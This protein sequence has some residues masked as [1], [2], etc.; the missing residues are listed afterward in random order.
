MGL[1][2]HDGQEEFSRNLDAVVVRN[3]H[4][5]EVPVNGSLG[6]FLPG[7]GQEEPSPRRVLG[8]GLEELVPNE[9]VR[10]HYEANGLAPCGLIVV[11]NLPAEPMR[12]VRPMV[13][14]SFSTTRRSSPTW[15][16][17]GGPQALRRQS[18]P[19]MRPRLTPENGSIGVGADA[20]S[21]GGTG[22]TRLA[23][24]GPTP[25][26]TLTES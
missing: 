25:P 17:M 6:R 24:R 7:V 19:L 20:A 3:P 9:E 12:F 21:H 11:L 13:T 2:W 10:E 22:G 1:A 14:A 4:E 15:S 8:G 16:P 18:G 26:Q 5:A 23:G